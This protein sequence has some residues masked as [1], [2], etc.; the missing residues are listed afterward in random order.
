MCI[1]TE[2]LEIRPYRDGDQYA[3]IGL[4]TNEEIKLTCIFPELESSADAE[5]MFKKLMA[6]SHADDH[7]ERGV[8]LHG[9]L[10]G[11]VFDVE[12]D[13]HEIEIGYAIHPSQKGNGYATEMLKAV[14]GNLF[15]MKYKKISACAFEGN[16]ASFRVMEKCGMLKSEKISYCFYRGENHRCPYYTISAER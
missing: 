1:Q 7:Y 8:Y 4:L 3:V 13:G 14:I 12:K 10:I 9:Q 11:F 16:A 15:S 2:R 5:N 6:N